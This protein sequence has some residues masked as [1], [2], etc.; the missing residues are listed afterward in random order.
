MLKRRRFNKLFK[1]VQQMTFINTKYN[2]LDNS[3]TRYGKIGVRGGFNY[4]QNNAQVDLLKYF[5]E[6]VDLDVTLGVKFNKASIDIIFEKKNEDVAKIVL[7]A[8]DDLM[9]AFHGSV[10][11]NM[12]EIEYE[13]NRTAPYYVE[14]LEAL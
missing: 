14:Q 2:K 6:N 3:F 12:K 13:I 10:A 9:R 1:E 4:M 5:Q 8:L 11:R 7:E